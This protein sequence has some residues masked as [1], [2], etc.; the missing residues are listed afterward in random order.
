MP[1][2]PGIALC[3]KRSFHRQPF[4]VLVK[5]AAGRITTDDCT[6]TMD[7]FPLWRMRLCVYAS[8]AILGRDRGALQQTCLRPDGGLFPQ[9]SIKDASDRQRYVEGES[10]AVW[11]NSGGGRSLK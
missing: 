8:Y 1:V 7:V 11:G 6:G 3:L 9:A 2:F 10:V 4:R 5:S